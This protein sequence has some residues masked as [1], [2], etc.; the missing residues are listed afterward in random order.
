MY[1]VD[2]EQIEGTLQFL[3]RQIELFEMNETWE[4][5]MERAALERI[6]H[7]MIESVLDVGNSMIDGFIMRDPGSYEDIIDILLDEKVITT[8]MSESLKKTVQFRKVLVQ[9]YTAVDHLT[10]QKS[11]EAELS[12]LKLF[13]VRVLEYLTNELGP[14]SAFKK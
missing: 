14:V 10:L 13:S 4:T 9:Q 5:P 7:T 1:F 8:E 11:F 12:E 6:A 2:R 3:N